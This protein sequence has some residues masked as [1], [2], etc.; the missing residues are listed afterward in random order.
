[1]K[2]ESRRQRRIRKQIKQA[3]PRS[4]FFKVW[5]GPFQP[6]GIPDL[7]GTVDGIFFAFEVKEPGEH[8]SQIQLEVIDDIRAAGGVAA[9]IEEGWEAI[10][11]IQEARRHSKKG[12]H[13]LGGPSWQRT[14][15]RAKGWEDLDRSRAHRVFAARNRANRRATNKSRNDVGEIYQ[16]TFT[17]LFN[18]P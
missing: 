5:G 14:V 12:R 10:A 6:A 15:Y 9:V 4:W 8:P 17:T 1:M 11:L 2:S 7:V 18:M 13:L 3:F 16:R